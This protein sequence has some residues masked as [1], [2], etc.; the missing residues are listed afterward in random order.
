[1][2]AGAGSTSSR[3][4]REYGMRTTSSTD[5]QNNPNRVNVRDHGPIPPGSYSIGPLLPNSSRRPLTAEPTNLMHGRG[6][7]QTHG[8]GNRET[9]S[10]GCVAATT[11]A[12]RDEFNRLM[13]LEE[14]QNTVAVQ[15]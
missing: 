15:P 4:A 5:C 10:K 11:N 2:L 13:A 12:V 7:F 14:G 8:C 3:T 6:G 1:M 9:C